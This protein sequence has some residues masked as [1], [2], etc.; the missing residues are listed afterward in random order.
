MIKRFNGRIS[1]VLSTHRFIS[2]EDLEQTLTRYVVPYN[3][4]LPQSALRSKTPMQT[5]KECYA[6]HPHLFR[7]R[8]YDR[9][10]CDNYGR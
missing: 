10:G 9:P 7:K 6:A 4:H 8:P 3:H 2:G 1:D 5:V